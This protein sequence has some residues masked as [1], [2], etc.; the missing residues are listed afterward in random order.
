[1]SYAEIRGWM[2]FED[3][4][5]IAVA[6]AAEGDT[7]IEVGVAYG[8]GLAYLTRKAMDSGKN[9][10]VVG[11][12]PWESVWGYWDDLSIL[13][14]KEGGAHEAF[15]AEMRRY[16]P[17]ERAHCVTM[18]VTSVRAA[19]IIQGYIGAAIAAGNPRTA[20]RISFVF[21]DA[22]HDYEH[23]KE[24]IAAWKPLIKPGGIIAGH[25]HTPSW[26]GVEQAVR[27]AFPGGYEVHKS[28]WLKRLP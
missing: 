13:V 16:A 12:D 17:D 24:D 8:K 23:C 14:D 27:E 4:Y 3:V 1:M 18:Q 19:E 22:V 15:E 2:D 28:S 11:V 5:D 6:E 9:L 20:P 25:D 10:D 21:I 7:L 26:P